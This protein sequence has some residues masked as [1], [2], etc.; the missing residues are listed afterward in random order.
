[1]IVYSFLFAAFAL[2]FCEVLIA[3]GMIFEFYGKLLDRLPEWIAKPLGDC[4]LC[5]AG[6]TALWGYF[7]IAEYNI[8]QHILFITLTIFFIKLYKD[9]IEKTSV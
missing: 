4:S 5:F 6:Q 7:L 8:L 9:G 3:P 2:V 1:M